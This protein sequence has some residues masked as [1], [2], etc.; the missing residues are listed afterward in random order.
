MNPLF[1]DLNQFFSPRRIAFVGATEDLSKFGGRCMRLLIDFG[2]SGEIYPVN[3]KRDSIFGHR[4][5]P[6][7][8]DLPQR[9][10]HVGIV[11]PSMGVIGAIEECVS[12]GVPFATLFSAGFSETG[13]EDGRLLQ[14]RAVSIAR[15]GGLRFMGPNCNGMINFVDGVALTSTAA[16][17]GQRRPAGD[18]GIVSQSGGAGQISVMW[19]AQQAGLGISYQVSCGNDADLDLLDY[20]AY[21][22]ESEATQVVMVV[23]ERIPD[24]KKLR[25]LANRAMEL[26]KPIL[27]VKAGRTLAGS[28][29]AASHTG[30]L[31]GSECVCD[32]ALRQMGIVRVEDTNELYD[33]AM[34]LRRKKHLY[35]NRAAST[36]ISGGN[37][38]LAADLGALMGIDFPPYSE[39]TQKELKAFLP[40]FSGAN[41]PTDLTSAAIGRQDSL[42]EVVK[43]ISQDPSIDIVIPII[44]LSQAS[45]IRGVA[46]VS[47]ESSKPFAI[48]WTGCAIDDPTLTHDK[49]VAQ[50][51]AVYR[52]SLQCMKAV[53]AAMRYSQRRQLIMG[54]PQP[55]RPADIDVQ[56]ARKFLRGCLGTL[57]E[58]ES[59]KLLKIYGIPITNEILAK[60]SNEALV[61][62]KKIGYPVALKIQSP[63]ILHKSD[64][65]AIRLGVIDEKGVKDGY[66][67]VNSA[68]INWKADAHIEGILVQEMVE[69]GFEVIIG[70]SVDPT[71]G[72]VITVGLGGIYVEIIR[73]LAFRVPPLGLLESHEMLNE[74]RTYPILSGARGGASVD[75][76]FLARCIER[77]SWLAVDLQD[78][79]IEL[80]INPIR[81]F[82]GQLG[83]KVVD[84]L[85]VLR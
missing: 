78:C 65:G 28:R 25:T 83:G 52:D 50:G 70:V 79:I 35:G 57:S 42:Q 31:T 59:K 9:P 44:T 26:D 29:M 32:A 84:A 53:R 73:D 12:I 45:E 4:C 22:L 55:K 3:P 37:L 15:S 48:L 56:D 58:S 16:I 75:I 74:L 2:F 46:A 10:D 34:L 43:I 82:S 41:N 61:A 40:G 66:Q 14:E 77:V 72:P 21:M 30:S 80:D 38:V 7:L 6:S 8:A 76:E 85:A 18:L 33:A 69:D 17:K 68:A 39:N 13:T 49:L 71:F 51:H 23:A 81:I 5:Y 62:A 60:N 11:L 1:P 67:A 27:M 64:A 47:A 19:R 36:S 54:R 20:I 63:D 24:S